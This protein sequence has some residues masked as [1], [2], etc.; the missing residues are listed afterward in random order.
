MASAY[1]AE[2]AKPSDVG[3]VLAQLSADVEGLA[4]RPL[5][6]PSLEGKGMTDR[7]ILFSAP[8]VRAILAGAKTVTRRVVKW[9]V[10][11]PSDGSKRRVYGPG[12]DHQDIARFSPFGK[13]G[14]HLWVRE[15][16][17]QSPSGD[18]HALHFRADEDEPPA[19]GCWRPSIFLPRWASRIT[20][21]VIGVRAERLHAVTEDDAKAEGVEQTNGHP[22]LG[23]ILGCGPSYREGFAQIW[24]AI[25]GKR[26]GCAWSDNPWVWAVSFRRIKP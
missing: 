4:C 7:P 11:G 5:S 26:P 10:L 1:G 3:L 22:E 24:R 18:D 20:L 23:A 21:E 8:M 6:S 14:D 19:E 9:P 2:R 17:R 16:W 13:P 25:N 15:T 12:S